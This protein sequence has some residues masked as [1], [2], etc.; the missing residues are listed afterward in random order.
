MLSDR[1]ARGRSGRPLT[2]PGSLSTVNNLC[3]IR[4]LAMTKKP[5][6]TLEIGMA[7]G[8]STLVFAA[9]HRDLGCPP[10]KQH[11]A[12]DPFQ[13]SAW[14]D[15]GRLAIERAG[16]DGWTDVREALSSNE[17]PRLAESREEYDIIYIDGSHLFEDVFVD[18]YYACRIASPNGIML[19][20]DASDKQIAKVLRFVRRNLGASLREIDLGEFRPDGGRNVKYRVARFLGKTQ[21]RGFQRIGEAGRLAATVFKDF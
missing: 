20:D 8:G 15:A 17:L 14:D 4:N 2:E 10:K 6:K 5:R 9:S 21:M 1:T 3:V 16:L 19:F 13:A 11:V 12:I 18:L 7:C